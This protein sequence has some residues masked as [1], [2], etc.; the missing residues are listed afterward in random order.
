MARAMGGRGISMVGVLGASCAMAFF[1]SACAHGSV[2]SVKAAAA[3]QESAL[4]DSST[5]SGGDAEAAVRESVA[6]AI[7][8][9]KYAV[10]SIRSRA[11]VDGIDQVIEISETGAKMKDRGG[12]E[13][14]L[15]ERGAL[16]LGSDGACQL[17]LAVSVDGEAPGVSERS[18]TWSVKGEKFFL[19]E[20]GSTNK[21]Q[22]RIVKDGNRFTLEGVNDVGGDG[23]VVG[24][25]KGERIVLVQGR[26]PIGSQSASTESKTG[27]EDTSTGPGADEI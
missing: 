9:G 26:G 4:V 6:P 22:Y 8:E 23:K 11:T 12:A 3:V 14:T 19:G 1:G 2:A 13:H 27:T 21:T 18:C 24:D 17:A 7:A 20:A 10:E 15:T 25:A 5:G 16:T